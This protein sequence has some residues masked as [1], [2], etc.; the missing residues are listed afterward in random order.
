MAKTWGKKIQNKIRI[1]FQ[2]IILLLILYVGSRPFFDKA[3]LADFESYC[4][5]GGISSL[6]SKLNIGSMACN[7]SET[8]VLL[9]LVLVLCAGLIG[10]LFCS[11][12]CPI[13][14]V[15]EWIGKIGE[16]LKIRRELPKKL[17]RYFRSLKYILLF[18]TTYYTMT[19]SELFCKTFDPYF[20]AV[21]GFNNTDIVLL[22]AI[23]AFIITVAG[24][25]FF[26]LFW[27]KYLC[28]LG[29]LSNI[30]MNVAAAITVIAIYLGA[31]YFGAGLSFYWLLGGLVSVGLI[32]ELGFMK[33]FLL[34]APKIR[35]GEG[36]SD[37]GLCDTKCP[38]GIE[39]SKYSVVNHIDC[40]LCTDCVY[41]CPKKNI[42][43]INKK[44]NLK[45]IAP[46]MVIIFIAVALILAKY[47]EFNTIS[48]R[49]GKLSGKEAVYSQTG[50]KTI[51]C[52][53][54]SM[55][56]AGTLQS[57][58]GI[59]GLDTY[60]KSH[61]VKI[62]YDSSIISE[63]KVKESLFTPA[64]VEI[65]QP[66]NTPND[67]VGVYSIGIYGLFDQTDFDNLEY[68]LRE[69]K[70]VFGFETHFGEPVMT[71]IYYD[72]AVFTPPDLRKRIESEYII[73]K[74]DNSEEK[75]GLNFKAANEGTLQNNITV[76]QYR[77]IMFDSFDENFNDYEN[78]KPGELKVFV[79]P[80]PDAVNPKLQGSLIFM[81][82]HLSGNEGI[83][84]FAT[85]YS[86]GPRGYVFFN[87]SKT[88]L[89]A[90]KSALTI[91]KFTIFTSDTET[92]EMD[93]PFHI[94]P[95][96][97]LYNATEINF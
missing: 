12:I 22:Y 44:G 88:N 54:S 89:D 17:D 23:P 29:A 73:I 39:V 60:A 59:H 97:K 76:S 62:Y 84:R 42:L 52:Y 69:K 67:P 58:E 14:T 9:G 38:Q 7:M 27:C 11:Y 48:L 87:A 95:E 80:M 36:C 49:W 53:G 43:T 72:P 2:S 63:K 8:Q 25:L 46:I 37:C 28:P 93:N 65:S 50:I 20:A 71:T 66:G 85:G 13:G 83:V 96:G 4:P 3:Y 26:R 77:K 18:V 33:S 32:N 79:F 30:F 45:Y 56:L 47:F 10:K 64:K 74:K 61:T 81:A 41:S 75:I 91:K 70:G 92:E 34:P 55:A 1:T 57:I 16:K 31:N 90:I 15:T 86:D 21:N 24:A 40:N 6:F 68:I 5:F 19:S 94:T 78:Y 35:K 82:S 51:K